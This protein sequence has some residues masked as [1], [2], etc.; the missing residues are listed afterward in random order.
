MWDIKH[1][2]EQYNL[3]MCSLYSLYVNDLLVELENS[4][5]GARLEN[6][7]T[8]APMYADDLALIATSPEELQ[9]MLYRNMLRNGDIAFVQANGI[10]LQKSSSFML[11]V[12]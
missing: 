5:M 9:G 10:R 7:Y 11:E 12:R 1:M 8:G 3:G 6:I 4:G 2:L